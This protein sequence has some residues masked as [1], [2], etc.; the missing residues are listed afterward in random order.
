[1]RKIL[2]ILAIIS[3]IGM[4][5]KAATFTNNTNCDL[6]ITIYCVDCDGGGEEYTWW[7][8]QTV[9]KRGGTINL[10]HMSCGYNQYKVAKICYADCPLICSSTWVNIT[11]GVTSSCP[12][13]ISD[14][15]NFPPSLCL[16][17]QTIGSEPSEQFTVY[18]TDI[19]NMV[20]VP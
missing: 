2:F 7:G 19:D 17:T 9:A 1:M 10:P 6:T 3:F 4:N 13:I 14:E 12:L 18:W 16:C 5:A 15:T 8:T 11:Q 20:A